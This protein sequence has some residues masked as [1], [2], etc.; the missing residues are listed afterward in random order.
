MTVKCR[1]CGEFGHRAEHV[2]WCLASETYGVKSGNTVRRENKA[3]VSTQAEVPSQQIP[4]Q[5]SKQQIPS[6]TFTPSVKEEDDDEDDG[7]FFFLMCQELLSYRLDDPKLKELL[8][9]D[10][11]WEGWYSGSH[12]G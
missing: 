6:Q 12:D 9:M 11:K 8:E 3:K 4:S 5:T 10:E 1:E 2:A 7:G